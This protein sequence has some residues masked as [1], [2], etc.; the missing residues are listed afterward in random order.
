MAD[1]VGKIVPELSSSGIEAFVTRWSAS[2]WNVKFG[3]ILWK[4]D[5]FSITA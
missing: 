4:C 3:A 2:T 1:A 5:I